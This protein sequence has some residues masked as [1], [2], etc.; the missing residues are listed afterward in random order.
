MPYRRTPLP[1]TI[2]IYPPQGDPAGIR[3]AEITTRTVRLFEVPRPL[4]RD[5]RD[6]PESKQGA[7]YFL[8]GSDPSGLESAYIGQTGSAG[9]RLKQHSDKKDFWDRALVAVSLTNS[10]TNTHTG[11]ME[12]QAIQRAKEAGRYELHNG[13]E[14][15]NLH[16]PDPLKADCHEY[17]ETISVLLTT[18]GYPV[19]EQLRE[20]SLSGTLPGMNAGEMLSSVKAEPRPGPSPPLRD[21]WFWP[22]PWARQAPG[23]RC[24]P[25]WLSGATRWS[26]R[27]SRR[28]AGSVTSLSK[29]TSSAARARPAPSSSAA[30]STAASPG[31]LP[32][33]RPSRTSKTSH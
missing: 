21:S 19:L 13:N 6:M 9:D 14:A 18:L 7:V 24:L 4:L 22:A 8:F 25:P 20:V 31:R 26:S 15:S 11:Y 23:R 2:Q 16:T 33:D 30:T 27:A 17:L 1:Q 3:M 28:S 12:W 29:T 10:W 5:F 32:W